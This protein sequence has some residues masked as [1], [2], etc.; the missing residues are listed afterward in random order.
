MKRTERAIVLKRV[1]YG[2]ADWI[3]TLFTEERGRAGGIA[4]GARRSQRRFGGA[5]E[6]GTLVRATTA[7]RRGSDLDR[8][9]EALVERSVNGALRSLERIGA[10]TRALGLALAFLQEHQPAADK[11]ALL[12]AWLAHLA[13]ADPAPDEA[14]AFELAWLSRSGYQPHLEACVGCGAAA[15]ASGRWAFDVERGGLVCRACRGAGRA[16]SLRAEDVQTLRAALG[17]DVAGGE[18]VRPSAAI[19]D[20]YIGAILGRPLRAGLSI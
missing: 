9:D 14:L 13:Q 7:A 18:D 1:A 8:I 4:R 2:E 5:L 19:I 6:P 11:F 15:D 3:V 20:R 10:M 16:L 12:D 17:A